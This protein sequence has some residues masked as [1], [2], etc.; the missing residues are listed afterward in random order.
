M[1]F[2]WTSE[3]GI[4]I[5]V[6]HFPRESHRIGNGHGTRSAG[7]GMGIAVF[8]AFTITN[9]IINIILLAMRN[10]MNGQDERR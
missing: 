4:G 1:G 3:S 7:M 5:P 9:T 8:F 6:P 2:S 10:A